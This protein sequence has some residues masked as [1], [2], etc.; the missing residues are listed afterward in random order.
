MRIAVLC[1][2]VAMVWAAS[3]V[4]VA[5][6]MNSC[7]G[8]PEL[9]T[10]CVYATEWCKPANDG[11]FDVVLSS[12]DGTY[13]YSLREVP[14]QCFYVDN[15]RR[16]VPVDTATHLRHYKASDDLLASVPSPVPRSSFAK[17][18]YL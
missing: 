5:R 16:M 15:L 11:W 1:M 13:L 10:D 12:S 3:L 18:L 2:A 8:P 4:A 9:R 7:A 17:I 6:Y 14:P